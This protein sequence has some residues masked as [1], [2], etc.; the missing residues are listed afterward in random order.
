MHGSS[1]LLRVLLVLLPATIVAWHFIFRNYGERLWAGVLLSY[2]WQFQWRTL[3][4]SGGV[5][6]GL[7]QFGYDDFALYGVPLDFVFGMSALC[8]PVVILAGFHGA[9]YTAP[10]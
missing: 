10:G 5:V 1:E 4:Y 6:T 7:W 2:A 3:L 9:R 8:G